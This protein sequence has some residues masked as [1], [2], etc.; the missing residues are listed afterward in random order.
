M[1]ITPTQSCKCDEFVKSIQDNDFEKAEQI[2]N[3]I[4]S[5]PDRSCEKWAPRDVRDSLSWMMTVELRDKLYELT[6]FYID[7][8]NSEVIGN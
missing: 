6:G 5:N 7:I 3:I 1:I 8:D 2:W 4:L